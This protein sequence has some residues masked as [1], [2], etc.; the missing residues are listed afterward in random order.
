MKDYIGKVTEGNSL[1]VLKN[2]KDNSI[3]SII[4]DPLTKSH[5]WELNGIEPA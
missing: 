1:E 2:F 4:T 5:S 3:D